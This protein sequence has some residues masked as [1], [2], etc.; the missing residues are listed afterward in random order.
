MLNLAMAIMKSNWLQ[1]Y[2]FVCLGRTR[3]TWHRETSCQQGYLLLQSSNQNG[4]NE[5]GG[6]IEKMV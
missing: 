4:Y 1:L 3:L 5:V 6:G 2:C